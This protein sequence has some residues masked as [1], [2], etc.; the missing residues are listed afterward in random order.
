MDIVNIDFTA[1]AM[2]E[3]VAVKVQESIV[4]CLAKN[5]LCEYM[6]VTK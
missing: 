4:F 3:R 1:L 6:G 5:L 2:S